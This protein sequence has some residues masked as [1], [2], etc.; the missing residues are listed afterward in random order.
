[1]LTLYM[2]GFDLLLYCNNMIFDSIS[3]ISLRLMKYLRVSKVNIIGLDIRIYLYY[4]FLSLHH[5]CI[6]FYQAVSQKYNF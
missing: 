4:T 2:P 5:E 1:M 3:R 6:L